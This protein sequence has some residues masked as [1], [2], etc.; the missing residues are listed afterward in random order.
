MPV[1]EY[2]CRKCE[3]EFEV[4]QRITEEPL[5]K[6]IF[7]DCDG[8]VY[9]KISKNVGLV[10]NGSGFYLTDYVHKNNN[11]KTSSKPKNDNGT[12]KETKKETVKKTETTEA[13]T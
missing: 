8:E 10:F 7:D 11:F 1:Y 12:A 2:K 6:C 13:K 9:R 3:R 5:K 4:T